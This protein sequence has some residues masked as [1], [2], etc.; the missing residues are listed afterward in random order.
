MNRFGR[1]VS[2]ALLLLTAGGIAVA[3]AGTPDLSGPW[4]IDKPVASLTTIDGNAPP[5]RAEATMRYIL[6]KEA[7]DKGDKKYDTMASCLPPGVPRLS[8][9]PFPWTIVQDGQHLRF[10]Y[11]WNQLQRDVYMEGEH[12]DASGSTYL[13]HSIGKWEGNTLVVDTSHYNNSTLLDD[14]G[15]PHSDALQ[16]IERYRLTKGGKLLELIVKITDAQ[17]YLKPWETRI[18]FKKMPGTLIKDDDCLKRAGTK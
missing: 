11:E 8:L 7:R 15:L 4:L 9:Q 18:T 3:A 5:L 1:R 12:V 6:I 10:V 14:S 2:L 13:G 17:S 16:T